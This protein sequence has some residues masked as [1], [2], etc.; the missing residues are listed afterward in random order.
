[1]T[2]WIADLPPFVP[3]Y[4]GAALALLLRGPAR[5]ALLLVVPL[6]GALNLW[7]NIAP[8]DLVGVSLLEFDLVLLRADR[9]SLLFGWLFHLAALIAVV[10][11]L[12][13]QDTLQQSAALVYAGSALGAVFAGACGRFGEAGEFRYKLFRNGNAKIGA[14]LATV[15]EFNLQLLR[16]HALGDFNLFA[17]RQGVVHCIK[18][19]LKRGE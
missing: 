10:F 16:V 14:N 8:G 3:F 12:H 13:E 6:L 5:S 15:S 19:Y 1:M 11:S 7:A 2:A 17:V 9:L 18:K 4:A